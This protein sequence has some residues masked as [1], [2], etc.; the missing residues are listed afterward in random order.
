[1]V[2]YI[3][4]YGDKRLPLGTA[5]PGA[6]ASHAAAAPATRTETPRTGLESM[7]I[8]MYAYIYIYIYRERER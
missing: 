3:I 6:P 5:K 8:N 4:N 1:M 2:N 7:Y